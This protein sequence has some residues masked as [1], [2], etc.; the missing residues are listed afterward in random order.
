MEM[1]WELLNL[2]IHTDINGHTTP[3]H[4]RPRPGENTGTVAGTV[5]GTGTRHHL[6]SPSVPPDFRNGI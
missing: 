5:T 3:S 1:S 4:T 6:S 2:S